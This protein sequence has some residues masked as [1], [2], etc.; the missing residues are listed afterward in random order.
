MH[1]T[2]TPSLAALFALMLCLLAAPAQAETIDVEQAKQAVV[3]FHKKSHTTR[4][5]RAPMS[6]ST[7]RHA[8]TQKTASGDPAVYAFNTDGG[9]F[10]LASANDATVPVLGY[11]DNGTFDPNNIPDGLKYLMGE[12]AK[13]IASL[14][15]R[16]A[17]EQ[18][19]EPDYK[20]EYTTPVAPLLPTQWDQEA[21]YN[22]D[23]PYAFSG[24]A[25]A[26]TGCMTTA[27]AQIMRFHKWPA[28]GFGSHEMEA[29]QGYDKVHVERNYY[30]TTYNWDVMPLNKNK[31]T[32]EGARE[33]AKLMM[34]VAVALGTEFNGVSSAV[35]ITVI[36]MLLSYFNYDPSA[37]LLYLDKMTTEEFNSILIG[38][39]QAGR[40]V[41]FTG[42]PSNSAHAFV[43]DGYDGEGLFHINWG[44]SGKSDGY[45]LVTSLSPSTAG[46]GGQAN[47]GYSQNLMM[48]HNIKPY[49][50]GTLPRPE[51]MANYRREVDPGVKITKNGTSFYFGGNFGVY[52]QTPQ[53]R[54]IRARIG[55]YVEVP[56]SNGQE[57]WNEHKEYSN[58]TEILRK[59]AYQNF[60]VKM[61]PSWAEEGTRVSYIYQECG[62][63][64]WKYV[65][66][67]YGD[68]CVFTFER[69]SDGE[70]VA[71][72]GSLV[73]LIAGKATSTNTVDVTYKIF[74]NDKEIGQKVVKEEIGKE[75]SKDFIPDY[76]NATGFPD[77]ISSS[78]TYEIKTSYKSTMPIADLS[79]AYNI[80]FNVDGNTYLWTVESGQ[81]KETRNPNVDATN[82]Q[83]TKWR[84]SGNWFDGFTISCQTSTGTQ[85]LILPNMNDNEVEIGA[86][87]YY[88]NSGYEE[89]SKF[90]LL[91]RNDGF[92]IK[93][94]QR[95]M[96]LAHTQPFTREVYLFNQEKYKGNIVEITLPG[97]APQATAVEY[98]VN[99]SGQPEGQSPQLTYQSKSYSNGQTFK[100]IGLSPHLLSGLSATRI[101]GYN[102]SITLGVNTVYVKYTP[103]PLAGVS[104]TVNISI[105]DCPVGKTP[106]L[107]YNGQ[108]YT[109]GEKVAATDLTQMQLAATPI[110]GYV[111]TIDIKSTS[112]TVTYT[113]KVTY[114]IEFTG[115]PA[116][117]NPILY[118]MSQPVK[119]TQ[120][121]AGNLKLDQLTASNIPNYGHQIAINGTKIKVEYFGAEYYFDTTGAIGTKV[122]K[123]LPVEVSYYGDGRQNNIFGAI[124]ETYITT[125]KSTSAPI[126]KIVF[127]DATGFTRIRA[128]VGTLSGNT[129]TC[130]E[131]TNSV[132]FYAQ[133]G[134]D[135]YSTGL[136]VY[137]K[138][139]ETSDVVLTDVNVNIGETGYSTFYFEGKYLKPSGLKVYYC[140]E[141]GKGSLSAKEWQ[142]NY[143]PSLTAFIL[144]GRPNTTY[145]FTRLRANEQDETISSNVLCG[146]TEAT[147]LVLTKE[148]KN[149]DN[150]YVFSCVAGQYGFY[151]FV[152]TTLPAHKAY[153]A[154]SSQAD[155]QGFALNFDGEQTTGVS[156]NENENGCEYGNQYFDLSGRSCA[157][158]PKHGGLYIKNG[159][160]VIK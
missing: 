86:F 35:H 27:I 46:T 101:P 119:G 148:E 114:T 89:R 156:L 106:A 147:S 121:T 141:N 108:Q 107:I 157:G 32:D 149:V 5:R 78:A 131:G 53:E 91:H 59:N 98:T 44:W 90:L 25:H 94:K 143:I 64:K 80:S 16:K 54:N 152:G 10:V 69:N 13:E 132:K 68:R 3:N 139:P 99:I 39:L 120:L 100:A 144:E 72:S 158:Q 115:Q 75:P 153:Y 4:A 36:P 136:T 2:S 48:I 73:Y 34:D 55:L 123:K 28:K 82:S 67:I 102:T 84:F 33:V 1:K 142:E 154:P 38:D 88:T 47:A 126:V 124:N 81:L 85:Y 24:T 111:Y 74:L 76:V 60:S 137:L 29:K 151:K 133:N 58:Y 104:Y 87:L 57:V 79:K 14:G 83:N 125:V 122:L 11:S 128:S 21:P 113:K 95:P 6:K 61:D 134:G 31:Y 37:E 118:Y 93:A 42:G 43:C 66:N 135:G 71:K 41:Y 116:D 127:K 70:L 19:P 65:N 49:Q 23:C 138:L 155:V 105:D 50:G 150:I 12:Y 109:N 140:E 97:T 51:I 26:A 52:P 18:L 92:Y 145:T 110:D 77:K 62:E 56:G 9:G 40:P 112:I 103:Q 45:Y 129:W 7:L 15:R 20:V 22:N 130:P 159:R 117:A 160:K 146:H 8:F 63:S 30:S 17:G 96:Y